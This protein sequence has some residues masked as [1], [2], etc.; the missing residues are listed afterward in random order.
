V[1]GWHENRSSPD[2][3]SRSTNERLLPETQAAEPSPR[4]AQVAPT[5]SGKEHGLPASS[6]RRTL[7]ICI[8][9]RSRPTSRTPTSP[10]TA[11][12]RASATCPTAAVCTWADADLT[13][14][15]PTRR[16]GSP[17]GRFR[18]ARYGRLFP[19][20]PRGRQVSRSPNPSRCIRPW[21]LMSAC[22]TAGLSHRER[23]ATDSDLRVA[24]GG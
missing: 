7:G 18:A 2:D 13:E 4:R 9:R 6:C 5:R 12:I 19:T 1:L 16:S 23:G 11:E 22:R 15:P 3:V 14:S 17:P 24:R 21:S 10:A 20:P 8:A